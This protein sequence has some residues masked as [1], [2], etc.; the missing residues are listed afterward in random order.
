MTEHN[1]RTK[2]IAVLAAARVALELCRTG[3]KELVDNGVRTQRFNSDADQFASAWRDL[4]EAVDDAEAIS[5]TNHLFT[6][7]S[8]NPR[9]S[10]DKIIQELSRECE[11]TRECDGNTTHPVRIWVIRRA[12]EYLQD[13]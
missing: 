11:R 6:F 8:Y 12:L 7:N 3:M 4:R 1:E 9:P 10:R 13:Q 2:P 5:M